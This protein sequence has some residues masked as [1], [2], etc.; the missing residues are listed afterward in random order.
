[1]KSTDL[2]RRRGRTLHFAA[3]SVAAFWLPV[4]I[5]MSNKR[6]IAPS[7]TA[8]SSF[9]PELAMRRHLRTQ[10]RPTASSAASQAP[11]I[12]TSKSGIHVPWCRGNPQQ[13]YSHSFQ[14]MHLHGSSDDEWNS[15]KGSRCCICSSHPSTPR[16]AIS[17]AMHHTS[18]CK[19]TSKRCTGPSCNRTFSLNFSAW[20]SSS[21]LQSWKM[22]IPVGLRTSCTAPCPAAAIH[23]AK[24][25]SMQSHPIGP[26]PCWGS[27]SHT[28]LHDVFYSPSIGTLLIYGLLCGTATAY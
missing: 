19:Q 15:S 23:G 3:S 20:P 1:M 25:C 11:Q 9:S 22:L 24:L 28:K 5:A 4:R 26:I 27:F 8:K 17:Q 14:P 2:H 6:A 12:P 7:D 10:V 16:L 13:Q 21:A 18:C